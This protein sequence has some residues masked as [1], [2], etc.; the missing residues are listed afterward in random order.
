M[1]LTELF[2][3]IDKKI[4]IIVLLI[5]ILLLSLIWIK[6][7]RNNLY[8]Q[9][10]DCNCTT[11]YLSNVSNKE[12]QNEENEEKNV[13]KPEKPQ[14]PQ[15][16][17]GVYYT[18]WCGHSKAFMNEWTNNLLPAVDASELKEKVQFE[19]IDCD[20]NEAICEKYKISGYPTILFH[21][22]DKIYEYNGARTTDKILAFI[23]DKI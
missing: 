12:E 1:Y 18:S 8:K 23:R 2:N 10:K 7:N 22:S 20:K 11:E 5:I 9:N 3:S 21:G 16:K 17:L 15:V 19:A 6:S 14:E 13:P 4:L